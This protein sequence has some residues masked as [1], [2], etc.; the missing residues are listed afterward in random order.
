MFHGYSEGPSTKDN[1]HQRQKTQIT[2]VAD[3]S[4]ATIFVGK[5]D[6]FF[7][8]NANKQVIIHLIRDHL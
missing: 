3:I 6:N 1:A 4:N 2:N 5:K 8:N 7:A